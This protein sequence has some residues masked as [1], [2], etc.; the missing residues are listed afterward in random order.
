ML[1][2]SINQDVTILNVQVLSKRGSRYTE[3][4][5]AELKKKG[6]GHC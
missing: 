2:R 3:Q 5:W 4:K 1:K 6:G